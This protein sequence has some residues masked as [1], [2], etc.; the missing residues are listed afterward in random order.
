MA[1]RPDINPTAEFDLLERIG[2]GYE[3]FDPSC[4]IN[5]NARH[6]FHSESDVQRFLEVSKDRKLLTPKVAPL[7]GFNRQ[8]GEVWKAQHK[9]SKQLLAIKKILPG[10][11]LADITKEIAIMKKCVSPHVVRYYGNYY[12]E[13]MLWVR[14]MRLSC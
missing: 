12:H 6:L 10:A 4:R 5:H 7:S 1:K 8:F 14:R 3:R 11:A 2:K 13:G 9:K